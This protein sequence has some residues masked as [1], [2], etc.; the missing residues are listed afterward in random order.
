MEDD[1]DRTYAPAIGSGA[2]AA[3]D[4]LTKTAGKAML[5]DAPAVTRYVLTRIPKGPGFIADIA[6]VLTAKDKLRSL[7]GVAGGAAGGALGELGGP[8][9]AAVGA[10]A[11]QAGSEWIYDHRDELAQRAAETAQWMKDRTAQLAGQVAHGFD[12]GI[13][14]YATPM[15]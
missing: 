11:G 13:P 2:L 3:A 15:N 14:P 12:R 9:G 6:D 8:I 7:V 1:S 4:S 10:G 5:K